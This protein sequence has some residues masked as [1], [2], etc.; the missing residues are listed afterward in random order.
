[1]AYY[2]DVLNLQ[3]ALYR[4]HKKDRISLAK[5]TLVTNG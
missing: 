2:E 1:V 4:A 3:E 5:T